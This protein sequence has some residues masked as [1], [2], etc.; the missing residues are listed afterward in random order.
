[1]IYMSKGC[2]DPYFYFPGNKLVMIYFYL[3]VSCFF[4]F[5]SPKLFLIY[6]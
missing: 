2:I 3:V 1:M 4:Q 6:E 5:S